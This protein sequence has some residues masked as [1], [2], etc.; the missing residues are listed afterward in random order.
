MMM[1]IIVVSAMI[2]AMMSVSRKKEISHPLIAN[3]R[4][5]SKVQ[6]FLRHFDR[7][8]KEKRIAVLTSK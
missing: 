5:R 6:Y 7:K 4:S 3:A 8:G 2:M 1:I